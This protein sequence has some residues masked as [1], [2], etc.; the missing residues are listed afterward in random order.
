MRKIE[1]FVDER[2]NA[3][4]IHCTRPVVGLETNEDHVPSKSL[5]TKPR[6]HHLP[7][8]T[9]CR[10]CNTSFALDEQAGST[11]PE[12]Q[13][14]ASAARAL[15]DSPALRE[16]IERSR[17]EFTTVGGDTRMLWPPETE[18]AQRVVLKNVL[19]QRR[20]WTRPPVVCL[21]GSREAAE[22]SR[23]P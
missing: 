1:D 10:E 6:P 22:I 23:V 19:C 14:N 5:L 17:S 15:A 12:K 4:C 7:I 11:A 2:Q 16:R 21:H 20:A 8:V 13:L 18:R 3:W 9:I